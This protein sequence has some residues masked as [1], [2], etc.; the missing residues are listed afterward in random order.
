MVINMTTVLNLAADGVSIGE[1]VSTAL[2]DS[3]LGMVVVFAALIILWVVIE[4]FHVCI[5]KATG[6]SK[7]KDETSEAVSAPE[8]PAEA[9]TEEEDEAAI[10]AAIT[11]A[12]SV[13][14]EAPAGSFRVVSFKRA[15]SNAHWNRR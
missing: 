6:K 2:T 3:L 13:M 7:K 12:I 5:S 1:R 4:I 10:V 8:V 9:A 14:T 15:E 11:A